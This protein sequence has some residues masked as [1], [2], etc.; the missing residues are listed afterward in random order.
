MP[1]DMP[2]LDRRLDAALGAMRQPPDVPTGAAG[3]VAARAILAN[4]PVTR[5]R[6]WTL[7]AA[8]LVMVAGLGA[9]IWRASEPAS[10]VAEVQP[11]TVPAAG[12]PM[13]T[14]TAV[15]ATRSRP[16]V[17]ELDAPKARSV[18]VV[19]DFNHWSRDGGTMQLG[20]DGHWRLTTLLPPG[21]YIYAFLVD[22]R[23][24]LR[25]PA[26][27]AVEDRDFGVTGSELVVAEAP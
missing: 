8:T 22:G 26:R 9:V 27:D 16:I 6:T 10:E 25:D 4:A 7:R 24:F 3:R 21:R 18:Q 15:T 5:V 12:A 20:A 19:G 13:P 11:S 23:R 2:S 1:D 14:M 17:F